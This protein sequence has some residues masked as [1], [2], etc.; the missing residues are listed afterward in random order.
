M[1]RPRSRIQVAPIVRRSIIDE[2]VHALKVTSAGA[3]A[4]RIQF[5]IRSI[6]MAIVAPEM[7]ARTL[8]GLNFIPA[9]LHLA[10]S[11]MASSLTL[12]SACMA[13]THPI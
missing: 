3:V 4:I 12:G 1:V 8:I 7:V 13:V 11:I 9:N 2:A 10:H 5:R 6:P